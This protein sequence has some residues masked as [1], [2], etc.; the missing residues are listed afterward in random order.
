VVRTTTSG[1]IFFP[2]V[3][4]L[5]FV[6]ALSV[7]IQHVRQFEAQIGLAAP[8]WFHRL[9][10]TGYDSVILF[11]VISG[12]LITYLLL[13]EQQ[14]TGSVAIRRFYVRR[15][16]RIW[17]LYFLLIAIALVIYLVV[18]RDTPGWVQPHHASVFALYALLLAN[19]AVLYGLPVLGL[20]QTWTIAVE[21]QFYLIWPLA[22][23]VFRRHVLA[24]MFAV[25]ALKL[26]VFAVLLHTLGPA[27]R[28]VLLVQELAFEA[29]AIG[30]I[31]AVLA[32]RGSRLLRVLFHP[33]GQLATVAAFVAVIY[34]FE[35]V[36]IWSRTF[37]T[38]AL[39]VVFAAIIL[40]VGCNER[41]LLR[42]GNPVLDYLGRITYGLYMF[43][44]LV[45]YGIVYAVWRLG[46]D[47][48]THTALQV[49]IDAA[50]LG[51]TIALGALSYR[52]FETPFLRLKKR[53]AQVESGGDALPVSGF[54]GA[55]AVTPQR[56]S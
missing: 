29:L 12:F 51:G 9:F 18:G 7:L 27:S 25:V 39:S 30:G 34:A 19:V 24:F 37:G 38:V 3:D 16:L 40:N 21:E 2:G 48:R 54:A 17:P 31:A 47:L 26:V 6:A 49:A 13:A 52:Y 53:F 8:G 43:H 45:M 35:D 55:P 1:R 10:L 28:A 20:S 36:M 11:F 42:L 22:L 4:A 46:W 14:R 44:P 32:F 15:I 5:R 33:L 41:T 56:A 23:R 50:A